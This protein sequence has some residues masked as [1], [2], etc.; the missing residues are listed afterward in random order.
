ML[1]A[2]QPGRR[3][4]WYNVSHPRWTNQL[5]MESPCKVYVAVG[6]KLATREGRKQKCQTGAYQWWQEILVPLKTPKQGR[7]GTPIVRHVCLVPRCKGLPE[8]GTAR[9]LVTT[10]LQENWQGHW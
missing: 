1:E 6:G 5:D 3:K 8:V 10:A 2:P 9:D 7:R 4:K